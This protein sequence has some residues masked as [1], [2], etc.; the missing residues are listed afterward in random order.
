MKKIIIAVPKGRILKEL[1]PIVKKAKI[2][3]EKDFLNSASRKLMFKT[4][5]KGLNIIRVRSFD[6][7]TFV[8]IGAAQIGIAGDDVLNEFNY[9]EIYSTLDLKIGKCRLSI[10]RKNKDHLKKQ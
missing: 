2:I 8:A 10:A 1:N 6:V 7:A 3:P 5:L 9:E 4:N